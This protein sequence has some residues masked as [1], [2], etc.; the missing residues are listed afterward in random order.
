MSCL[1]KMTPVIYV[2]SSGKYECVVSIPLIGK[3]YTRS[4]TV[5]GDYSISIKVICISPL[6]HI[7][8]LESN[9]Q[10]SVIMNICTQPSNE[11]GIII[12]TSCIIISKIIIFLRRVH[13]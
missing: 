12:I 13:Y 5:E 9:G 3:Q 8:F 2:A 1:G 4:F 10:L 11:E 7:I 6:H